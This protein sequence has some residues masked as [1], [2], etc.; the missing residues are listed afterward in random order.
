MNSRQN[1]QKSVISASRRTDIP[2]F[3]MDWF[4]KRLS[5]G[6]FETPNP[7]NRKI[8]VTSVS[9]ESVHSIVFWSKNFGPFIKDHYGEILR[10]QGYNIFFNFTINSRD[11]LL[12]P[13]LPPLNDRIR[14]LEYLAT[15]FGPDAINWR[16]D[17]ICAY[18]IN[19]EL[20][21]NL[22]DFQSITERIAKTNVKRCISSFADIYKKIQ[23]RIST[24]INLQLIELTINDKIDAVL[25]MEEILTASDINLM[26]CC[27]SVVLDLLPIESKTATS[28]CINNQLLKTLYGGNISLAKATGQRTK[29]GCDCKK[30]ID[31][32][33]Y[34]LQPCA[35]NCLYC[36]ANP[37][38]APVLRNNN[39]K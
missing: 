23:R 4:M 16:F 24:N 39:E 18:R 13:N 26:L 38:E 29:N 2:A 28:S 37:V 5:I 35:H 22:N 12:E 19:G 20:K 21:N 9:P 15:T 31:I 11:S 3:Y 6:T 34:E 36:Y 17:P 30:S 8:S 25:R 7:Y 33:S 32:G 14:Q 10:D 27:E 1:N